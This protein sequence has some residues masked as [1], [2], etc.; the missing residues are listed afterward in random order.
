MSRNC[1]PWTDKD[2]Q[3]LIDNFHKYPHKQLHSIFFPERTAES[4]RSQCSKLGLKKDIRSSRGWTKECLDIMYE[5]YPYYSNKLIHELYLP[6]FTPKQIAE[7]GSKCLGLK[8]NKSYIKNWFPEEINIL[9]DK[10]STSTIDELHQLIPRKSKN[11]IRSMASNLGLKKTPEQYKYIMAQSLEKSIICSKPQQKINELLDAL[12]I[13]YVR[14]YFVGYYHIDLYLPTHNLMIEVQGDYWHMSPL[15]NKDCVFKDNL[16]KS[17]DKTKHKYI[18]NHY[19]IEILYLWETDINT[20]IE[21]CKNLILEYANSKGVLPN[22]HSFNY[23]FHN[24]TLSLLPE[25]YQMEY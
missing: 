22:Y 8:K 13:P 6:Q 11:Q 7:F 5:K 12:S 9:K 17:K 2:N 3:I 21:K 19:N 20:D 4:V 25:I 18:K 16:A 24:S 15:F 23:S 14:E 10:Y 1:I